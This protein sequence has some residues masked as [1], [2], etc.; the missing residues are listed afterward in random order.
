MKIT[1]LFLFLFFL[2]ISTFAHAKINLNT[3]ELKELIHAA[4]YI[5]QKRAEA[6]ITYRENHGAFSSVEEL[7]NVPTFGKNFVKNRLKIFLEVFDV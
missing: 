3:A 2:I 6:I 7:A 5:G 4:P 1:P